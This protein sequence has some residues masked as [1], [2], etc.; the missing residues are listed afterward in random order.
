MLLERSRGSGVTGFIREPSVAIT[1]FE[2]T[3]NRPGRKGYVTTKFTGKD[4]L[5]ARG[6]L[7]KQAKELAEKIR[8]EDAEKKI[9]MRNIDGQPKLVNEESAQRIETMQRSWYRKGPVA[10]RPTFTMG[11][12]ISN[13]RVV[14]DDEE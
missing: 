7:D 8:R 3:K 11:A 14:R 4:V 10:S 6:M 9:L 2:G 12:R 5:K 1:E 13:G